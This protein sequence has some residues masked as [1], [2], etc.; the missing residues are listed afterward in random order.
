MRGNIWVLKEVLNS[1]SMTFHEIL[2]K[3]MTFYIFANFHD[4]PGLREP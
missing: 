3:S 1:N 4:F 2:K